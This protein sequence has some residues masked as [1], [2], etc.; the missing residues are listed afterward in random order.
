MPSLR[1][2][3]SFSRHSRTSSLG[4]ALGNLV[5]GAHLNSHNRPAT[6]NNPNNNNNGF[7]GVYNGNNGA[8]TPGAA[9]DTPTG[10]SATLSPLGGR[11]GSAGPLDGAL[12]AAA[13]AASAQQASSARMENTPRVHEIPSSVL[14]GRQMRRGEVVATAVD[15]YMAILCAVCSCRSDRSPLGVAP[16]AHLSDGHLHLI[17]VRRCSRAQYL[18]FLMEVARKGIT[19]D[20]P[21]RFPFIEVQ[22]ATAFS[23]ASRGGTLGHW[24][25]D[26]E[27]VRCRRLTGQVHM[28]LVEVFG[29]GIEI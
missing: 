9:P 24:N 10:V 26:G 21:V 4:R 2:P 23:I 3:G 12:L 17:L 18:R 1:E 19:E 14:F 16:G 15:D 27:L 25:V 20:T 5:S 29:R 22:E 11:R 6:S 8:L 28:G 7:G 13:A